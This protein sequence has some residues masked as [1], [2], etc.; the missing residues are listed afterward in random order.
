AIATL[1]KKG[2]LRVLDSC[3]GLGYNTWVLWA[4]L[5]GPMQV[6]GTVSVI[7]LERDPEI[8]A[9]SPVVLRAARLANLPRN[10]NEREL[11][12][13]K[14]LTTEQAG[15]QVCIEVRIG[16]LRQ[17]ISQ[18]KGPFDLIFHD[19]FSPSKVPELWTVDLFREYFRLLKPFSG[20]MLT[21]SSA[22]A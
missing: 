6:P 9:L 12:K 15:L 18:E 14:V 19:P 10:D 11:P 3:F 17:Q 1:N 16:D 8:V 4:Q 20:R 22:A 21:Y 7:A 2:N 5:L 13:A